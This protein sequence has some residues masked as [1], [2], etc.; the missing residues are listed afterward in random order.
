MQTRF[1]LSATL[2]ALGL[3]T[4]AQAQ[5]PAADY[6]AAKDRIAATY[7][8]DKAA[9][10]ALKDNAKDIC[11]EEAKGKEKVAKAE[12]EYNRTNLPKDQER[13]AVAKAEAAYEVA[14]ERCDDRTGDDKSAC[15]KE[16][17][18]AEERAKADAKAANKG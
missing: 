9:C 6:K 18:A 2:L 15:K 5:M 3:S 12:L 14:K 11:T 7:K 16:A 1:A 4:A 8:A 13:L 10:D 17:K